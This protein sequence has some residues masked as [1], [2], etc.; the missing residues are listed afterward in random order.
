MQLPNPATSV[1][2]THAV[3]N[4][5]IEHSEG[6]RWLLDMPNLESVVGSTAR[7]QAEARPLRSRCI[8]NLYLGP[9]FAY[10]SFVARQRIKPDT[11]SL[12]RPGGR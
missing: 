12:L 6:R 7:Y 2:L 5:A 8:L 4:I 11:S 10:F 9:W 1:D 3:I